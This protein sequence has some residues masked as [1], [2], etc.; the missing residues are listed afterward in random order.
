MIRSGWTGFDCVG[1]EDEGAFAEEAV[2]G[3]GGGWKD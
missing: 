2:T 3:G 1:V